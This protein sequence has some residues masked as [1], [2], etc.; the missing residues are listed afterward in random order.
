MSNK[1][2]IYFDNAATTPPHPKVIEK[3]TEIMKS[4]YGNPSSIHSFGRKSRV[5]IE[6]CREVVADFINVD[7]SEIYFTS[8]GT[9]SNNM[10][11]L[12]I[13]KTEYE[14]TKRKHVITNKAEHHAVLE[15]FD[16]LEQQGF[17]TEIVDVNSN[18][19]VNFD[20]ISASI[21]DNT[22][23]VSVMHTNNET[24]AVNDL[25]KLS[26]LADHS[27]F[28]HSDMVQSFGKTAID[29]T[30]INVH[31]ISASAHKFYGPKGIGL[32][33]VKSGT[34]MQ[35]LITGGS[36]ERNRRGGTENLTGIV[37]L[38]EAVK[39]AKN[40]MSSNEIRVKEIK[41]HFLNNLQQTFSNRV[42]INSSENS[43]PYILSITFN[44]EYYNNDSEAML[45]YL[46]I[47]GI[48]V[49]NGAACTSGTL[50]PSHVILSMNM[51]ET[52]AAGTIRFSFNPW[53]TLKEVDY[54]VDVLKK[55]SEKFK[56]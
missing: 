52:D 15:P 30:K 9:E 44:S 49:S 53:N 35:S 38:T 12:G 36:Q 24:G 19:H 43:T 56:K 54:T 10:A 50:K 31:S 41:E 32:L 11:I 26:V 7:P 47:N 42:K 40:D 34:P 5:L 1:P 48:A 20:K 13:A 6:E 37:G 55:M 4:E 28:V 17:D 27:V 8:G 22:S 33:Y 51:N 3:M 23:L 18:F 46:D 45:M 39:I 2:N 29:L 21:N 25:T 14:D 16:K